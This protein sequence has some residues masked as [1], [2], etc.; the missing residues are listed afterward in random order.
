MRARRAVLGFLA[1]STAAGT[2]AA[3]VPTYS[4]VQLQARA[5]FSG[6][7]NLPTGSSFNSGTPAINDAGTV[8]IRLIVVGNTGNAGLWVGSGGTGAVVYDAPV[9]RLLGDVSINAAGEVVFQRSLD[10]TS[11]GVWRYDPVSGM[12]TLAVPVGGPLGILGFSDPSID[13]TG[14]VG[15]RVER[16]SGQAYVLDDAGVQTLYVEEGTGS[17]AFLFT[18]ETND[19]GQMAGKVRLGGLGNE[20]PDEIRRY[21][22]DG[23]FTTMAVDADADAGS[24]F[25]GFG[26][27]IGLADNGLVAF[28]GDMS[29]G[30]GVFLSDGTT[31]TPIATFEDPEISS[32]D[33]FWPAVNADGLVVFRAFEAGG[34]RAIFAG[35]GTTLRRVIGEHD[36]VPID[37]GDA[38]IDRP[39]ASPVFGGNPGVNAGGD[40]VFSASLTAVDNPQVSH[41]NGVF[42]ARAGTTVAVESA[43]SG[44]RAPLRAAPTP[45]ARSVEIAYDVEGGGVVELE[46][47]G[48]DGRRVRRLMNVGG[49]RGPHMVVW[50]GSDDAGR[51]VPPGVYFVRLGGTGE[52]S[53]SLRLVKAR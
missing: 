44:S 32:I 29:G 33:F 2:A 10:F 14:R 39:D 35:D 15:A 40:I 4:T 50:D 43:P 26:N 22:S 24:P 46:V 16:G 6:G 7:F 21:E 27:G 18:A 25:I 5:A 9:D 30:N 45:F 38:R 1:V 34:T 52:T 41:G 8:S 19:A 53:G 49:T 28:V 23:S 13:D 11:E 20:Q 12:T 17:I 31:V 48:A 37:L 3:G 42:I 47:Y 51:E 36:V